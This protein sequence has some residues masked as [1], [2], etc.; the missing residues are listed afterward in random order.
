MTEERDTREKTK[1]VGLD[2]AVARVVLVSRDKHPRTEEFQDSASQVF[3][4][5]WSKFEPETWSMAGGKV[6]DVDLPVDREYSPTDFEHVTSQT[7][8][9]ELRAELGVQIVLEDLRY[10]GVFDNGQW[11]T[12]LYYCLVDERPSITV[13]S[14]EIDGYRWRNIQEAAT[15]EDTFADHGPMYQAIIAHMANQAA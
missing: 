7:A 2:N 10:V 13:N 15:E 14:T 5:W 8:L 9:R 1:Q 6:E 3:R 11:V 4:P 12:A